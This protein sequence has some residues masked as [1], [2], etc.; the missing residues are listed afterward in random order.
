M[1]ASIVH[2]FGQASLG[3]PAQFELSLGGIGV[4]RG[5]IAGTAR[6]NTVWDRAAAGSIKI[7]TVTS[8]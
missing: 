1:C 3:L 6:G 2:H 4:A 5:Y 7:L 8:F